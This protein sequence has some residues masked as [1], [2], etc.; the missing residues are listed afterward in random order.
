MFLMTSLHTTVVLTTANRQVSSVANMWA[1]LLAQGF[2][3]FI[4]FIRTCI[5]SKS[6]FAVRPPPSETLNHTKGRNPRTDHPRPT[7]SPIIKQNAPIAVSPVNPGSRQ[8]FLSW[9]AVDLCRRPRRRRSVSR[10][11]TGRDEKRGEGQREREREK[12]TIRGPR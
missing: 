8:R 5:T 4:E 12:W 10:I 11:L 6:T 2:S 7:C 9:P 1:F 3:S